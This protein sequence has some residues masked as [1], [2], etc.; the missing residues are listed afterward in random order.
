VKP[1][2]ARECTGGGE[3]KFNIRRKVKKVL[4]G[5]SF[6]NTR[7]FMSTLE[8]GKDHIEERKIGKEPISGFT[9]RARKKRGFFEGGKIEGK[10]GKGE[11]PSRRKRDRKSRTP[12]GW[13]RLLLSKK[14]SFVG[15]QEPPL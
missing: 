5:V 6:S 3:Q 10:N 11:G 1:F 14:L 2:C 15:E 4:G 9:R 13:E 8:G 7:T 12:L